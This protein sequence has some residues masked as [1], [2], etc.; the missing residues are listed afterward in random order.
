VE[1][2]V[3]DTDETLGSRT[4]TQTGEGVAPDEV[5]AAAPVPDEERD[6]V[7]VAHDVTPE[8]FD[9]GA[10]VEGA[11]PGRRAVTI[12]TRP[13][14][15]AEMELIIGRVEALEAEAAK[16]GEEPDADAIEALVADYKTARDAYEASRR[17]VIVEARSTEWLAKVEKDAKKRYRLDPKKNPQDARTILLRQIAGQIVHPTQGVTPE[18]L[19]HL[20]ETAEPELDKLFRACQMVNRTPGV[21]PD[22]SRRRSATIPRG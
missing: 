1:T 18:A 12:T 5:L 8:D 9:F 11:R 13:D 19:R 22:F 21:A 2:T 3:A 17:T 7:E 14:L 20:M 6:I 16:V 15:I 4:P 10:F